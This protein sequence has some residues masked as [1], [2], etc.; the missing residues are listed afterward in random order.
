MELSSNESRI[1]N[2]YKVIML[3]LGTLY[4][5]DGVKVLG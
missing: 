2:D 4:R 3:R 5:G 1:T